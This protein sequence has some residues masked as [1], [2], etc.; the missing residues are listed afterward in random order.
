METGSRNWVADKGYHS[1][2]VLKAL[3]ELGVRTYISEPSRDRR[4]WRGKQAERDAVYCNRRR[5]RGERGRRLLRRRGEQ[6]E[7]PFAHAHKTG[8][9]RR[10]YLR[11][12]LNILKRVLIHTA[13]LNLGVLMRAIVGV[14][15]PRG[16]QGRLRSLSAQFFVILH[17]IITAHLHFFARLSS[18]QIHSMHQVSVCVP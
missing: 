13:A 16:L 7:R 2:E 8:R 17:W 14:G 18:R 11:G 10:V 1:N 9:L 15:T 6:L 5:I 4:N 3:A 12:R